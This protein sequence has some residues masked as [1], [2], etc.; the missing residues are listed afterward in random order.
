[1]MT[2]MIIIIIVVIVVTVCSKCKDRSCNM[3]TTRD[4]N[5]KVQHSY[6]CCHEECAGGCTGPG[7]DQ[8]DVCKHVSHNNTCLSTCPTSFYLVR[9]FRS[10]PLPPPPPLLLLV[11]VPVPFSY[12]SWVIAGSWLGND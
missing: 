11:P 7:S 4:E 3:T 5:Q 1:M 6:F 2:M 9:T 12:R 8:C 10:L